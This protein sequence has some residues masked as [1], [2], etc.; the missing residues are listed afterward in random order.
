M[1]RPRTHPRSDVRAGTSICSL[2]VLLLLIVPGCFEGVLPGYVLPSSSLAAQVA[3]PIGEYTQDMLVRDGFV[4]VYL[5]QDEGRIYLELNRFGEDVLYMNAMATGLGSARTY[6]LDGGSGGE[7]AVIRFER[8]GR[9]VVVVRRNSDVTATSGDPE[10]LESVRRSFPVSVV[11][12]LPVVEESDGRALV[13]ATDFLLS[14]VVGIQAA[15]R[16]FDLGT[17]R[18]EADRGYV[19]EDVTR[20]FPGNTE[21]R[22]VLTFSS[23]DLHPEI[24]RHSPDGRFVTF[25]QHHTLMELPSEPLEARAFDP[26]TGNSERVVQD[27]SEG[28]DE[29]YRKRYVERWRLEKQDPGASVSEPVEP[30]VYYLDPATPEPYRSAYREGAMWWNEIFEAAGFRNGFQVRDLPEGADPM[31]ARYSVIQHVHRSMPGPSTGGGRSD[32]RT[33]EILV[34]MPRMDSHRSMT[35]YNI[36]AG[37]LPAFDAMGIEPQLSA[38]E[39]AMARR[40][41]LAAHEVGHSLGFP[42]NFIAHSQGR[43]SVMDY[44]FPLIE[45]DD[46]GRLDISEA[47][48][49]SGGYSDTLAARFAYTEFADPQEEREGL[50]SIV[51]EA[52]DRGHLSLGEGSLPASHPDVHRWV[53]GANTFEALDRTMRVRRVLLEHF[54]ERA[55]RPGEPL[56]WLNPRF[57]HV[58]LHHRY[59]VEGMIKNIGGMR[60]T[61]ALR[62]DGQEPTAVVPASDQRRALDLLVGVLSPNELAVPDRVVG[63]IPPFP[64]GFD[65]PE[66]WID[67]VAGVAR[68]PAVA[69][70]GAWITSPAGEALDPLAIARSFAQEVVDNLLNRQRM[71]RVAAF[72][73]L[74]PDQLSLHELLQGLVA[75]TWGAQGERSG[76]RGGYHRAAERAVLDGLF[77]L[78][79]DERATAEVRDAADMQLAD[80][81]E[82]L[83]VPA[84]ADASSIAHRER[85]GRELRR[86]LEDGVVPDLR[87][88]VILIALP[89]P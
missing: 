65:E 75:G 3:D 89:W 7:E 55:I 30:V 59:S 36:Y 57:A 52:L 31:D 67:P 42:H 54:D 68:P 17:V 76:P 25:E 69:S 86:Y 23:D 29:D 8:H 85:A 4:P 82:A 74:D 11:A 22:T 41:Q 83:T 9:R 87:T 77:T 34:G 63:L 79:T 18:L 39:F 43:S 88:G 28:F 32:P 15:V 20:A 73:A 58:Y 13:D 56:A 49:P 27:Y 12:S 78:A 50:R 46:M 44:P 47:Y 19:R 2:L 24:R 35:D 70:H 5:D 10:E 62:G 66:G 81:S 61:Y 71:A 26:R 14:D 48:R 1:P 51:R 60:F 21:I 33:G 45:L 53:A 80:L 38:E 16:Q 72:H 40:R 6:S 84:D 64:P 37:L